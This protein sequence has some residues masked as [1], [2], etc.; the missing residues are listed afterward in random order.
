MS[1]AVDIYAH[2]VAHLTPVQEEICRRVVNGESIKRICADDGMPSKATVFNWLLRD[3][4]FRMAYA[5][6]AHMRGHHMFEE[7]IEV[8]SQEPPRVI[9]QTGE[10]TSESRVDVGAV[11]HM[12][13]RV[14]TL[15]WAAGKLNPKAYG[16]KIDVTSGGEQLQPERNHN[17]MAVR[18]A[19]IVAQVK[20]RGDA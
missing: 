9:V 14:D 16:D 15:K 20:E 1:G 12:R 7:A 6:A 8:A 3:E 17:E 11:Q 18:L 4:A 10:D 13:L 5:I 2:E 19:A